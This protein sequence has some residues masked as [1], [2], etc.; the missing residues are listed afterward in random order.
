MTLNSRR[1]R[2]FSGVSITTIVTLLS[3]LLCRLPR[4]G[5]GDHLSCPAFVGVADVHARGGDGLQDAPDQRVRGDLVRQRLVG[6]NEAVAD[7][8]GG[9]VADVFPHHVL[10]PP[11]T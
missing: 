10:T 6:E 11:P 2:T 8:L 7:H 4:R 9:H 5:R 3:V 1:R